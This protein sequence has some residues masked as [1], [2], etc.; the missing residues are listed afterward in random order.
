LDLAVTNSSAKAVSILKKTQIKP[1]IFVSVATPQLAGNEFWA[2]VKIGDIANPVSNLFGVSFVL[3]FTHTAYVDAVQPISSNIAAAVFLGSDVVIHK[4]VDEA[5]GKVRV[6]ISRKHGQIGV[7]GSGNVVRVKFVTQTTIP[8]GTQVQFTITDVNATD[9][10]GAPISLYPRVSKVTVIYD[11]VCVWPGD[12]NNDGVV[13]QADV[14]PIGLYWDLINPVRPNASMNWECQISPPWIPLAATYA[15]ATGDGKVTEAD[16]LPIGLNWSK[17]HTAA[18]ALASAESLEKAADEA[19]PV[20]QPKVSPSGLATNQQFS[21]QIKISGAADLFGLAFELVY[22]QPNVMQIL[23]VEPDAFLGSDVI[24]YSNVEERSGKIAV[25]ISRK[26]GQ[27]SVNGAGSVVRI[28][29][30]LS[31]NATAGAKINF[32]LQN[33]TANDAAGAAI[34][35]SPQSSSL[36]VGGITTVDSNEET[37]LPASYRLHQNHPNPF[38]AGTLIKYE[39]PQAGPVSLHIYNL[40]GQEI[41]ELVNAIQPPGRYQV[42]WDGRDSQGKVVPSGVYVYRLRAGSFVQSQAMILT[43]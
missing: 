31:A 13:N 24:F 37:S 8:T 6:G 2:Y 18:L 43:K 33:V 23:S 5:A 39:I 15:D 21:V 27:T 28:K 11:S 1:P 29:A 35:L 38:N 34:S 19:G 30:K 3:N 7:N 14:L 16:V 25:G 12:T 26:A 41:L 36:T 42:N 17:T 40:A 9:P 22:D 20:I 32:F 10:T 4:A